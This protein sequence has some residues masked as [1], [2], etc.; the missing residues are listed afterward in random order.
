MTRK[1]YQVATKSQLR[2]LS[3]VVRHDILDRLVAV[4]PTSVRDLAMSLGRNPT[5]I[6]QHL[7]V[8]EKLG[9]VRATGRVGAG[10]AGRPAILYQAAGPLIRLTNAARK[11]ENRKE[12][13]R[14]VR[15]AT[16]QAARDFD[17]AFTNVTRRVT[18]PLRNH[19][20]Y[21]AIFAPSKER[22][23]RIN[24]LLSELQELTCQPETNPGAPVSIAWFLAPIS[25]KKLER[26]VDSL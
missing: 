16:M 18:G 4:G 11:G 19:N 5:A 7:R 8:L 3:S 2:A 6:Y 24:E 12:I 21:R 1:A 26:A 15:A 13:A 22:M 23:Q 25:P 17:A 9:L 20:F 10:E 14:V